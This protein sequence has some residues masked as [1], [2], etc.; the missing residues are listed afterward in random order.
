MA[1]KNEIDLKRREIRTD[2]YSYI[3]V[4]IDDYFYSRTFACKA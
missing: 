3:D 2:D 1:L 4:D